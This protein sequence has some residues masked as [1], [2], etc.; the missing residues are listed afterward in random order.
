MCKSPLAN[1]QYSVLSSFHLTHH[2]VRILAVVS[3]SAAEMRWRGGVGT[4]GIACSITFVTQSCVVTTNSRQ[5]RH[6]LERYRV[7]HEAIVSARPD[8][9]LAIT[10][11]GVREL[12]WSLPHAVRQSGWYIGAVD[13]RLM[14]SPYYPPHGTMD[15]RHTSKNVVL[16]MPSGWTVSG[17]VGVCGSQ[18][19]KAKWTYWVV[20]QQRRQRP[21]C[22]RNIG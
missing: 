21:L 16:I 10:H 15:R 8:D 20:Q 22:R 9:R 1:N 6:C 4:L 13:D 5:R 17:G 19:C 7:K 2:Y 3:L 11:A 12:M 14:Y 18:R